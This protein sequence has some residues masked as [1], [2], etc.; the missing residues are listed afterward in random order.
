MIGYSVV[1]DD[2]LTRGPSVG[3]L[4]LGHVARDVI[5]SLIWHGT[6]ITKDYGFLWVI[7]RV[8]PSGVSCNDL[9]E[10]SLVSV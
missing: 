6:I 5:Q 2:K 10:E 3:A 8:N 1:H 9:I 7:P 4:I